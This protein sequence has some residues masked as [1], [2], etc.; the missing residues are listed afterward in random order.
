M[1]YH[2]L[3]G[4][5]G[6]HPMLGNGDRFYGSYGVCQIRTSAQVP[7]GGRFTI[8]RGWLMFEHVT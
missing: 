8:A 2:E 3:G 6:L 5:A 4:D 7:V 1:G